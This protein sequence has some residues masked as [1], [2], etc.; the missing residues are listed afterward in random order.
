MF[1]LQKILSSWI[2]PIGLLIIFLLALGFIVIKKQKFLSVV[3]FLITFITYFINTGIGTYIFVKPLENAYEEIELNA[4]N[5][6]A[7]VVLGGGIVFGP[8]RIYLNPHALQRAYTGAWLAKELNIPVIV[9][10]GE[11]PGREE[12]P[13][14][15]VMKEVIENTGIESGKIILDTNARN[16]C[17]NALY[18][19]E[20]CKKNGFK[21]IL[22]V[23]SAVHMKRVMKCFERF[24]IQVTPY[25]TDYKYDYSKLSW[26]DFM[27]NP[28]ALD[29]NL[30]AF[31]ELIGI[32]WYSLRYR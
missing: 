4:S 22:V 32:I 7:V 6:D 31:H 28:Q 19:Y 12:I 11:S 5:F 23:T 2:M 15:V 1:V 29:A 21:N 9:T 25:P 10:G 16:T 13:E 8:Q 17:E 27:P 30:S 24:D 26:V 20:I 3:I 14:A 18:T